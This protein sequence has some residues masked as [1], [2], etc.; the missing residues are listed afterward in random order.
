MEKP[1]NPLFFEIENTLGFCVGNTRRVLAK[2]ANQRFAEA[3]HDISIEQ[4]I[5]MMVLLKFEG[6]NQKVIADFLD[7]DKT[8]VTR[9]INSLEQRNLVVRIPDKDDK[10]NKLLYLTFQGKELQK[11]LSKVMR[12]INQ[13]ISSVI[14]KTQLD[15]C[16]MVLK[17]VC[18]H[19][20][21][22]IEFLTK[23]G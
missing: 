17:D 2:V 7:R 14:E 4:A 3:G 15:I 8:S 23:I 18:H 6:Q 21:E 12:G 20:G 11:E 16:K 19:F 10:R 22:D 5:I 1:I 9:L 13:E